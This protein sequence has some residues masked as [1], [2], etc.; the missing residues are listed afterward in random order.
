MS[1]T[2]AFHLYYHV[3]TLT[4]FPVFINDAIEE[5][6]KFY[7][8]TDPMLEDRRQILFFFPPTIRTEQRHRR[9]DFKEKTERALSE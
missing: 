2:D 7:I 8:Y 1:I 4:G 6:M 3:A 5:Q 9:A